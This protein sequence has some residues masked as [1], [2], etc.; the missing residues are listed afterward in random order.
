MW[1]LLAVAWTLAQPPEPSGPLKKLLVLPL[2]ARVGVE[3]KKAAV[4]GDLL[5]AEARKIPGYAVMTQE[6]IEKLLTV[7]MRKQLMGCS[8]GSCMAELGG[9]LNADEVLYGSV[10]RLGGTE[11]VLGLSRLDARSSG[12][13]GS[14]SERLSGADDALIL[15]H[16]PVLLKRLYPAYTPPPP[17]ARGLHPALSVLAMTGLGATVQYAALASVL[18]SFMF[19]GVPPLFWGVL[20]TT[21]AALLAAPLYVAWLEAWMLDLAGK[22]RVGFRW[23]AVVG[24]GLLAL[25][26]ASALLPLVVGALMSTTAAVRSFI[27][28]PGASTADTNPLAT[29]GQVGA[30]LAFGAAGV[31]P[32]LVA[33]VV[34]VPLVQALLLY[35]M[36][37]ARPVDEEA[38]WPG[39]FGPH[40]KRPSWA[41]HLPGVLDSVWGG[42]APAKPEPATAEK[43]KDPP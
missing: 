9:S 28:R 37:D 11:L 23:A 17:Q 35:A 39:L 20:L 1:A 36:S 33:M 3:A 6:D 29:L 41:P 42:M 10:G 43:A 24:V 16:V 31:V 8:E 5:N 30:G 34:G 15:D 40:E 27:P 14:E 19:L 22:R 38:R 21:V 25:T 13:L 7:E 32:G 18:G 2:Q 26:G 12:V 4:M